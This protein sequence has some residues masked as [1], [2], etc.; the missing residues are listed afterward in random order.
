MGNLLG[1]SLLGYVILPIM[2]Y[3]CLKFVYL[4]VPT[5]SFF[6]MHSIQS[7]IVFTFHRM[8]NKIVLSQILYLIAF[9]RKREKE[10]REKGEILLPVG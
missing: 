5:I 9:E 2:L 8:S 4:P 7:R 3:H 6:R 1:V 10:E